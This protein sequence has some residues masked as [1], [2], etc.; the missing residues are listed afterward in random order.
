MKQQQFATPRNCHP[1]RFVIL[2]NAKDLLLLLSLLL[3]L[4]LPLI[5][6]SVIPAGNLLLGG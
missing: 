5:F 4:F 1:D 2:S 6:L 3:L